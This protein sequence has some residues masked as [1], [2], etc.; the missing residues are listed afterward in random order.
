MKICILVPWAKDVQ[1]PHHS[2]GKD[3]PTL[4]GYLNLLEHG[5]R[6]D[7]SQLKKPWFWRI[8]MLSFTSLPPVT[9][10]W[11]QTLVVLQFRGAAQSI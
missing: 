1:R 5:A 4:K 8:N 11:H 2:Q 3:V 10:Q 9:V 7:Q 6:L